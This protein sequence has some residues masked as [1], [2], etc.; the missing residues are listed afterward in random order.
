[1]ANKSLFPEGVP[2]SSRHLRQE[3]AYRSD[4]IKTVAAAGM[5]FGVASGLTVTVNGTNNQTVDVAAG[6]GWCPRGDRVSRASASLGLAITNTLGTKNY[7]LLVY[8]ELQSQPGSHES[9]GTTYNTRAVEN[10]RVV[11]MTEATYNALP[12][13]SDDLSVNAKDR[14]LLVA[15]VTGTGGALSSGNIQ[16][17]TSYPTSLNA[18][19]TG[20]AGV[21]IL[22]IG[23]TV[24][25]GTGAIT[26][27]VGPYTL[28]W[29]SPQDGAAGT[30]VSITST[31]NYTLTSTGGSTILVSVTYSQLPGTGGTNSVTISSIYTEQVPRLTA[32]DE[33]HRSLIGTGLPSSTNPHGMTL[34]DL[35]PG[36]AGTL[37]QH[38]DVLHTNGIVKGSSANFL[39]TTVN[40]GVAPDSLTIG[41]ASPGDAVYI[42]GKRIQ[43][44]SGSNTITFG[45]GTSQA[46]LYGIYMSQ[47]GTV[48]K[49]QVARF[50]SSPNLLNQIQLSRIS[51]IA[52]GTQTLKIDS[53][54]SPET[55]F[56]GGDDD[57]GVLVASGIPASVRI[58]TADRVGYI[59]VYAN[60]TP[61]NGTDS[62]TI[63]APPS[64]SDNLLLSYVF[65][66]GSATGFLGNGFSAG[67]WPNIVSDERTYGT[68]GADNANDQAG[69]TNVTEMFRML[70]LHGVFYKRNVYHNTLPLVSLY[71]NERGHNVSW[72]GFNLTYDGGYYAINGLMKYQAPDSAVLLPNTIN[73]VYLTPAGV[74]YSV[75][76]WQEIESSYPPNSVLRL[77]EL[78]T[79]GSTVTASKTIC[80][81]IDLT[82]DAPGGVVG[83]DA[84]GR[85]RIISE[86]TGP[87]SGLSTDPLVTITGATGVKG[88]SLT[89]VS[90]L[91]MEIT[92]SGTAGRAV[93]ITSSGQSL[94][95]QGKSTSGG[96][97]VFSI[98]DANTPTGEL[99]SM[100]SATSNS[101][102]ASLTTGAS[103]AWKLTNDSATYPTLDLVNS[104]ATST[105]VALNAARHI[106]TAPGYDFRYTAT[107]TRRKYV[108]AASMQADTTGISST[109]TYH[110]SVASEHGAWYDVTDG[111]I[112]GQV[113]IP[114]DATITNVY[115][116]YSTSNVAPQAH[117]FE[118][119]K[120]DLDG[121]PTVL[122]TDT[123]TL[124]N[125]GGLNNPW[126]LTF[127][128]PA[129]YTPINGDTNLGYYSFRYIWPAAG[130]AIIYIW[131]FSFAFTYTKV[132]GL[133]L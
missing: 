11:V 45:D 118:L 103:T 62:I 70:G 115:L 110:Y 52:A 36:A 71:G 31:G 58:Y 131:G 22:Q 79:D 86:G 69:V 17:A 5:D 19:S 61:T 26:L 84:T 124:G 15:I 16:N 101:I 32:V 85:V 107:R 83:R 7:V 56:F 51:G 47:D 112:V 106:Q 54:V 18:S 104:N 90:N 64:S 23:Q 97:P 128:A 72:A 21:S 9:S 116:H 63:L 6:Y 48:F 20:F 49:Q 10:A 33:R 95:L 93:N 68:L 67:N 40:T 91:A 34:D 92:R 80:K 44:I 35:S 129:A 121:T 96:D 130:T 132:S 81:W 2:V 30:P 126:T 1:M 46:G 117:T 89:S 75:A 127:G 38:Q 53:G 77:Y 66:S 99:L 42:N 14:A 109:P 87:T 13:S 60:I 12:Q 123:S 100:I 74:G 41:A 37:E 59:D 102:T 125:T 28:A 133:E 105:S 4:E 24:Q 122:L 88:V 82:K 8:D 27:A 108:G 111:V 94:W 78:T 76:S 29:R 3:S 39:S 113:E 73:R 43:A 50:P 55:I 119:V 65:W 25:T 57:T 114:A 120:S 98:Q